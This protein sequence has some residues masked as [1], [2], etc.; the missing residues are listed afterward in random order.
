LNTIEKVK[1][2]QGE[3]KELEFYLFAIHCLSRDEIDQ[4]T[5]GYPH[6]NV[7][8]VFGLEFYK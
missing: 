4:L 7:S 2:N 5:F 3:L 8:F 1:E 6:G